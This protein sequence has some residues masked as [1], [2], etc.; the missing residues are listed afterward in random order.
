MA[1]SA[2][3]RL[4]VMAAVCANLFIAVAKFAAAFFTGSSAMV[5]EGVHSVVDTGNQGLL[6]FG[7]HRG[8]RPAD[9]AHPF[10]HGK[11]VYFW[12]L[13]VAVLLFGMGG[14]ISL[15]EG[16]LHILHPTPQKDLVWNYAVL[17]IAFIAEGASWWIAARALL[18]T[19]GG[20]ALWGKLR[21]SKDPSVYTVFA[22]DSAALIGLLLAFGGV[23]MS[24]VLDEPR[25]DGVASV[26]IGALLIGVSLFL[27]H[28]TRGLLV[29]EAARPDVVRLIRDLAQSD[30]AVI[31]VQG[32]LTMHLGPDR[33][34]V[35]LGLDF[36]RGIAA[37]DLVAAI[38]RVEASIRD[39]VPAVESIA[40]EVGS[41]RASE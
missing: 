13:M 11:E 1:G 22:E 31:G 41:L 30:A 6:L 21:A 38:G 7:M 15:Y 10:G 19:S 14:G 23:L 33:L 29:G 32:P 39:R 3:S 12:G 25:L 4:T 26:A 9:A 2:E 8:S 5:S 20:R 36:R 16:V 28:E 24:H 37:E 27:I 34:L 40:I 17:A 18:G 35:N